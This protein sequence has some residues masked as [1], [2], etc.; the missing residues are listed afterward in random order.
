MCTR[1]CTNWV[2]IPGH[3]RQVDAGDEEVWGVAANEDIYKRPAN[4]SGDWT[5]LHGKFTHVL[6][7][8]NGYVWAVNVN[9]QIYKCKKPCWGSWETTGL[10]QLDGG[11]SYIYGV[12]R[13]NMIYT[14]P[15]DGSGSWRQIPSGISFKHVTAS[16]RDEIYGVSP[17]NQV[18]R[19]KKPCVGEWEIIEA[20]PLIPCDATMNGLFGVRPGYGVYRRPLG[21]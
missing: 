21:I 11:Y 7:S 17:I 13:D 14:R 3:L 19:C 18:W 5:K 20:V 6:A 2:Q 15:I 12:G 8:G 1:P 4:G 9:T 16:G 10:K